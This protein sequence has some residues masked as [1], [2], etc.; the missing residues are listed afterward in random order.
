VARALLDRGL[1]EVQD[2]LEVRFSLGVPVIGIGAP[3]AF[4]LPAAAQRLQAEAVVPPDG[5]VA[6]AIGAITSDVRVTR[7]AT[8]TPDELGRF[9]VGGIAGAPLFV[10]LEAAQAFAEH[11]LRAQVLEL[12]SK[13]GATAPQVVTWTRDR[14]TEAADG[15][16]L[17]VGRSVWA[18]ASGLP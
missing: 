16:Q 11:A 18:R 14:I 10:E 2:A 4:F 6:N 13:A 1:G 9:R 15:L 17:F 12:A 8:I 7:E 3:A 5:D